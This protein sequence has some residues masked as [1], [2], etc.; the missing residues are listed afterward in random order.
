MKTRVSMKMATMRDVSDR[1]CLDNV[2]GRCMKF[3]DGE[4]R[5]C[6]TKTSQTW[7]KL[8]T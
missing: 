3:L 8:K 1:E 6:S 4:I 5:V 7:K 2:Y